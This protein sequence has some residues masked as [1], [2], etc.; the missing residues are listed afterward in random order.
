MCGTTRRA[1][2]DCSL[3]E[4]GPVIN[5]LTT[6]N[7]FQLLTCAQPLTQ[8]ETFGFTKSQ[9]K[10]V[11]CTCYVPTDSSATFQMRGFALVSQN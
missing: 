3:V 10:T 6:S 1:A 8:L 11:K 5:N 7:L 9:D 4:L 2:R